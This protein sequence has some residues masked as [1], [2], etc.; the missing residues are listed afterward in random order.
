MQIFRRTRCTLGAGRNDVNFCARHGER[1]TMRPMTIEVHSSRKPAAPH[2]GWISALVLLT[3]AT[4]LAAV[5]TLEK[6]GGGLED[7]LHPAGWAVSF[8]PPRRFEP[9]GLL[10][11]DFGS[12]A[13][14]HFVAQ[15]GASAEIAYWRIDGHSTLTAA[16]ACDLV[17]KTVDVPWTVMLFGSPAT[18]TP[19]KLA[20]ELGVEVIDSAI[21]MAV[22]AAVAPN[23]EAYAVSFRVAQAALDEHFLEAFHLACDSVRLAEK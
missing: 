13:V 19:E 18:Q 22:R 8:Q 10:R 6:S 17:L 16:R 23:G 14:F 4:S 3:V 20:G 2:R 7:R 21:G 15:G 9:T 5:M 12:A 11:T 1:G